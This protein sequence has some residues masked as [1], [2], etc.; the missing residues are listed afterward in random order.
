MSARAP[1]AGLPGP[2]P[3]TEWVTTNP[4]DVLATNFGK[5]A[6]LFEKVPKEDVTSWAA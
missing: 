2:E 4:L 6:P 3:G 1:L 5:P